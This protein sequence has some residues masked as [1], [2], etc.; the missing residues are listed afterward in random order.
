MRLFAYFLLDGRV[1]DRDVLPLFLIGLMAAL[2]TWTAGQANQKKRRG[3]G[4]LAGFGVGMFFTEIGFY[5]YEQ[6]GMDMRGGY[7]LAGVP[8]AF[9]VSAAVAWF[10][11]RK[12]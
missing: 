10:A 12:R 9:V 6:H 8:I 1:D 11:F 5:L 2:G 4:L 3:V 7:Y